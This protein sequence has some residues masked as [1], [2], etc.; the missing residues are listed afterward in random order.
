MEIS[1]SNLQRDLPNRRACKRVRNKREGKLFQDLPTQPVMV[2]KR[3]IDLACDN[4]F[5]SRG[6]LQKD[7]INNWTRSRS[8]PDLNRGSVPETIR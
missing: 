5:R 3:M 7:S 6:M 2:S 8:N 4:F 1:S